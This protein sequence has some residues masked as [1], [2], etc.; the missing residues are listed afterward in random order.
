MVVI[1]ESELKGFELHVTF[2]SS[3]VNLN[4]NLATKVSQSVWWHYMLQFS[5]TGFL[6]H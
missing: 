6:Y 4:L 1:N 3:N 2:I 5:D